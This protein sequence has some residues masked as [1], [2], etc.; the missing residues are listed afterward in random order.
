[1]VMNAVYIIF[2]YKHTTTDAMVHVARRT[3]L[4]LGIFNIARPINKLVLA[5]D[6]SASPIVIWLVL[7]NAC[8]REHQKRV[9]KARTRHNHE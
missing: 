7:L 5:T 6:K 2:G 3:L 8:Y 9:G 1:M 4:G